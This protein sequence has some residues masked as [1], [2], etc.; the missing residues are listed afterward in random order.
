MALV[1]Y[2]LVVCLGFAYGGYRLFLVAHRIT[3]EHPA[4]HAV[5]PMGVIALVISCCA[6][7]IMLIAG[8]VVV[9]SL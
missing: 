5:V 1:L 2:L 7:I 8:A 3:D 6:G 9:S 4:W